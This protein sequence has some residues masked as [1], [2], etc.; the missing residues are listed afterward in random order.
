MIFLILMQITNYSNLWDAS[1]CTDLCDLAFIS[2]NSQET[3][4]APWQNIANTVQ[5]SYVFV[6]AQ[7]FSTWLG[8]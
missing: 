7:H 1:L 2:W 3:S 5:L 4:P 8:D 6:L